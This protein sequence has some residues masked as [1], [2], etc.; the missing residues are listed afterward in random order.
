[1][2]PQESKEVS[3]AQLLTYIHKNKT[4]ALI[5]TSVEMGALLAGVKGA[6][7]KNITKYAAAIGFAFQVVDDILD[8]TATAKQLGKTNSDANAETNRQR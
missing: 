6:D 4:G 3:A 2:L 8:A 1:M 5:L 7:L